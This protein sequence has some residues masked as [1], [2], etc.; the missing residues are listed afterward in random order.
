LSRVRWLA[1]PLSTMTSLGRL[2]TFF[3]RTVD[4]AGT[5]WMTKRLAS[6][7]R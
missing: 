3:D 5:S 1:S 2:T 6:N 4:H 7:V